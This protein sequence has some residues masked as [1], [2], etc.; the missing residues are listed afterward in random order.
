MR[1]RTR[2]EI[3]NW[4]EFTFRGRTFVR[5]IVPRGMN[6]DQE[7]TVAHKLAGRY[8]V[9]R[10]F[11]S[12]GCG[13][14]L[15]GRDEQT[16]TEVL[17]KTTLRYNLAP[18]AGGRHRAGF[19]EELWRLRNQLQGER[20]IMV[21]LKNQGCN[22]IPNPN[23]YVFDWNPRLAEPFPSDGGEW[24]YDD[25]L[26]LA[27]EPYLIL[28]A[29]EGET[30]EELLEDR[31]PA[32]LDEGRALGILRQVTNVLRLLHRPLTVNGALWKVVYQDLKPANIMLG[33]HDYV[34]LIDLGGCR[35]T[36]N[37]RF[38]L[39]GASTPG[40]RPPECELEGVTLT[41]AADSYTVGATLF[42]LLTGRAPTDFLA[43][44]LAG[45]G[46]TVVP[47]DR[48]DW[49]ALRRRASL[50]TF[51]LVRACLQHAVKDRP[52]DGAALHAELTRLVG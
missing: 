45:T 44:G 15:A 3:D 40:Y 9:K 2:K 33:A 46:P 16:E 50:G 12:G 1:R 49:D 39:P 5:A 26:M 10:F 30:L 23:D 21:L 24:R 48:W 6:E 14:L 18:Y 32:G 38:A 31:R 22:A 7:Y 8:A 34:V 25:E 36:V 28:E 43:T 17:I 42:H 27:T 11:A 29:I 20:R 4:R 19:S 52:A 51:R 41:A 47:F 35:L 13:L 37:D